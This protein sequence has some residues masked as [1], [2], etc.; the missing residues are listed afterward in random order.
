MSREFSSD[1]Q[2]SLQEVTQN[3]RKWIVLTQFSSHEETVFLHKTA[4]SLGQVVL[5]HH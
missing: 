4:F 5:F 2:G 1:Q 3:L